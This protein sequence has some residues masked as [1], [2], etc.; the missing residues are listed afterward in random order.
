MIAE[1]KYAEEHTQGSGTV[2]AYH[3]KNKHQFNSK[4]GI[5]WDIRYRRLVQANLK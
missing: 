1:K 5:F 4:I 3:C 2:E